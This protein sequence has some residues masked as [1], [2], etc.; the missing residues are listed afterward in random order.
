MPKLSILAGTTS[1]TIDIY[2]QD[3]SSSVGAGLA[4]L[5]YNSA[6]LTCYY[7]REGAA[8]ATSVTLATMT[9]GTWASSGFKEIDGTNM[10]GWY[11]FGIPNAA[12][13]SGAK[14]A[15]FLFKGA[16][17]MVALPIE[18]ELTATDNQDAVRG[19]MT[20]MPNANAGASGGL[21]INGSNSGTVTLAALT[22]S[23]ATTHTGAVSCAGGIA[24]T[25]SA[26]NTAGVSIA[27]NGSAAGLSITGGATGA[28]VTVI[29]G[30]TS[31]AGITVTTTSGDG[32]SLTPTAGHGLVVTGN[33]ASKHGAIITG[34]TSGTSDG[35]KA[36]AGSGGV[37]IR[38][39]ITGNITGTLSGGVTVTTNN[40]KTGYSLSQSFPSNFASMSI[41]AGGN[42]SIN[43]QVKKNTAITNFPLKM[44]LTSDHI[45]PA[46]G[47]TVSVTRSIDGAAFAATATATATE[48]SNGWYYI[49]LAAADLNGNSIIIRATAAAC[50]PTE[51][52]ISTQP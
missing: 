48:I 2:I 37:P 41:S 11:Q 46:T 40:N 18:L 47:K 3:S 50:D 38:G 39:D 10:P 13:A 6:G 8:S 31:G 4:G 22:V 35:V 45:S 28:G 36:V 15:K 34:G 43:A 33:G 29:G 23:G 14:T 1:K 44:V 26:G 52:T 19:G 16:T 21:L 30:G 27:G 17:N 9:V 24:I 42:V 32:L 7:Y 20:A 5:L 25:Q 49:P 12:I 51:I